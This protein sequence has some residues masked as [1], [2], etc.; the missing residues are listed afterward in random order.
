MTDAQIEFN[1]NILLGLTLLV[2]AVLILVIWIRLRPNA[3]GRHRVDPP[4]PSEGLIR[5]RDAQPMDLQDL[6]YQPKSFRQPRGR[7][8]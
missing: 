5:P 1:Q 8:E 2:T 4:P 7:R 3:K 6:I